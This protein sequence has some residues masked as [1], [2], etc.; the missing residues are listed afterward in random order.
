MVPCVIG[1]HD[2][3]CAARNL[4]FQFS[5]FVLSLL[6]LRGETANSMG[7]FALVSFLG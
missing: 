6:L 7:M 3:F 2:V 5:G 4:R 1:G